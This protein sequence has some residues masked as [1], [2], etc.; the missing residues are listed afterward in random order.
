[1]KDKIYVIE[2]ELYYDDEVKTQFERFQTFGE[3]KIF[4]GYSTTEYKFNL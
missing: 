1:M 3:P 4:H 2:E